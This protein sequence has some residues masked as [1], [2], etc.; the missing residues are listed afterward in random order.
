[1][2]L[3]QQDPLLAAPRESPHTTVKA[4]CKQT[5]DKNR[6][7]LRIAPEISFSGPFCLFQTGFWGNPELPQEL[8]EKM[9]GVAFQELSFPCL[10]ENSRILSATAMG[11]LA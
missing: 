9:A 2:T 5:E 4:Q 6:A 8:N 10:Q 7:K 1:M 11:I 3:Q